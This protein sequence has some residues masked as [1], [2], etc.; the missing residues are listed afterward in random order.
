[1]DVDE[2][3]VRRL[4]EAA[5]LYAKEFEAHPTLAEEDGD[6]A[7]SHYIFIFSGVSSVSATTS[8]LACRH[9]GAFD[10]FNSS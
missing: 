6:F 5:F 7:N 9:K 3:L 1:L 2:R 10:G 8:G 4:D